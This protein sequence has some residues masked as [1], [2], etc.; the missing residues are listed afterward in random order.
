MVLA[1]LL[2][3]SSFRAAVVQGLQ[4]PGSLVQAARA[5]P[6][7]AVRSVLWRSDLPSQEGGIVSVF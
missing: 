7:Q 4:S 3:V 1:E 5:L 2:R 6:A